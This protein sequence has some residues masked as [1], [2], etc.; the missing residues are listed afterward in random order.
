MEGIYF[1]LVWLGGSLA[2]TLWDL[3]LKPYLDSMGSK[4][5]RRSS[6]QTGYTPYKRGE[7]N[8]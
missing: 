4:T 5:D 2:H 6:L 1:M 3:K 8:E 7:K